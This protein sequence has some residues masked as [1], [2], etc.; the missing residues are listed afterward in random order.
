[1]GVELAAKLLLL[2]LPIL[3]D[4]YLCMA[5][6]IVAYVVEK[7][8]H[9]PVVSLCPQRHRMCVRGSELLERGEQLGQ[10]SQ[11]DNNAPVVGHVVKASFDE[12]R[13]QLAVHVE[14]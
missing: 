1:V 7:A 4:Q 10:Q 9:H 3:G 11:T 8:L 12:L 13:P 14:A 5:T 2:L 6:R